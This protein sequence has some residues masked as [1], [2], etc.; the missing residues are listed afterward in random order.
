MLF[1]CCIFWLFIFIWSSRCSSHFFIIMSGLEAFIQGIV[2][3]VLL[4]LI[5]FLYKKI[6]WSLT[7]K[8]RREYLLKEE[9]KKELEKRLSKMSPSER[10][11]EEQKLKK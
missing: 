10:R 1:L 5:I 9:E 7:S 11:R 4:I 8:E 3:T 6:R 2:G